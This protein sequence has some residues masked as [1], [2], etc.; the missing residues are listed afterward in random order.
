MLLGD[1][2][3][4]PFRRTDAALEVELPDRRPSALGLALRITLAALEPAR[5]S[6]WLHNS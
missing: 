3:P 2:K 4:L 5:R 1:G 6:G